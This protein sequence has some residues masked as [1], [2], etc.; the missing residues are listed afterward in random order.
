MAEFAAKAKGKKGKG[1]AK[2]KA[3]KAA[4]QDTRLPVTLLSGFLGSG[5]TTLLK[6]ILQNKQQLRCAVIVN[7]MAELNIDAALTRDASVIQKEEKLVEM[8]NGCICCTLR[9]DLLE[10]VAKLAGEGRFDYLV[11]ESTGISEPLQVAETFT[12]QVP[13]SN[14]AAGSS[15]L[16]DMARL[17]TCVTVIDAVNF[18]STFETADFLRDRFE[19]DNA[20]DLRTVAE[21]MVDQIEFANVIVVNKTDLV[22][23]A[24]LER[25]TTFLRRLNPSAEIIPTRYAEMP[26]D[27]ILDTKRFNFQ[28]AQQAPGW[29]Q[30]ARGESVP[31]TEEYGISSFIYRARRP[32]A[33][34]A[35]FR[36]FLTNF[37]FL[38]SPA[39]LEGA[40]NFVEERAAE[41]AAERSARK[42][43]ED[44]AADDRGGVGDEVLVEEGADGELAIREEEQ[45]EEMELDMATRLENKKSGPFRNLLRSKGFFWLASRP[46]NRGLWS[47]AGAVMSLNHGGYWFA[48]LPEENW[49]VDAAG[50]AIIK[51]DFAE[52][53]GDKRNEIVLIGTFQEGDQ[54]SITAALDACLLS[55]AQFDK[56]KRIAASTP[57]LY[58]LMM[59]NRQPAEAASS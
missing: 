31:E 13:G 43:A 17:D 51:K 8:Q 5:K 20:E 27:K 48:D 15:Q 52:D 32:F 10:E 1:K 25:I 49:P 18:D 35:L 38:S 16:T 9:E 57:T 4:A 40:E 26:L 59:R 2:A 24:D 44:A 29:L 46:Y 36:L 37:H 53:V 41:I 6:H 50:K 56:Y 22:S 42:A 21:L 11:I 7:D 23:A 30:T 55:D 12:F 34:L 33:P 47:Q 58:E 39:M 19:V 28:E 3:K 45:D 14:G 54:E